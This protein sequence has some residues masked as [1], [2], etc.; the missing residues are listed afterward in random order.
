MFESLPVAGSVDDAIGLATE[1]TGPDSPLQTAALFVAIARSDLTSPWNYLALSV[2]AFEQLQETMYHDPNG[3]PVGTWRGRSISGD[4]ASALRYAQRLVESYELTTL[5]PT[6]LALSLVS[7]PSSG[8][9]ATLLRGSDL[10]HQ[11][12][13]R[14]INDEIASPSLADGAVFPPWNEATSTA[15][16]PP[17]QGSPPAAPGAP[18]PPV[19]SPPSAG[20]QHGSS[21][22]TFADSPPPPAPTQA[23]LPPPVG[24]PPPPPGTSSPVLPLP[25]ARPAPPVGGPRVPRKYLAL[26]VPLVLAAGYTTVRAVSLLDDRSP[27]GQ[28]P[29]LDDSELITAD[30]L[31]R[32]VIDDIR[33]QPVTF[34]DWDLPA[35]SAIRQFYSEGI[36]DERGLDA[37]APDGRRALTIQVALTSTTELAD[38][39]VN[40]SFENVDDLPFP[41]WADGGIE[42]ER[43]GWRFTTMQALN[44]PVFISVAVGGE[45]D[46]LADLRA[47]AERV[48]VLQ[49]A[50]ITGREISER[51][52]TFGNELRARSLEARLRLLVGITVLSLALTALRNSAAWQRRFRSSTPIGQLSSSVRLIDLSVEADQLRRSYRPASMAVAVAILAVIVISQTVGLP[53]TLAAWAAALVLLGVVEVV[54]LLILRRSGGHAPNAHETVPL[55][56]LLFALPISAGLVFLSLYLLDIAA[57]LPLFGTPGNDTS[58]TARFSQSVVVFALLAALAAPLPVRLIKSLTRRPSDGG[59][60][61]ILLLR[62]FADDRLRLYTGRR[63]SDSVLRRLSRGQWN[64]FEE[65]LVEYIAAHGRVKTVGVPGQTL[66]RLGATR[67][68]LG[69][70]WLFGVVEEARKSRNVVIIAGRSQHVMEEVEHLRQAGLLERTVFIFPPVR[71]REASKR[72]ETITKVLTG[73][74]MPPPIPRS[75]SIVSARFDRNGRPFELTVS[76]ARDWTSYQAAVQRQLSASAAKWEAPAYNPNSQL[77]DSIRQ[78]VKMSAPESVTRQRHRAPWFLQSAVAIL[79]F[80]F[81]ITGCAEVLR[82]LWEVKI[83]D[84][85]LFRYR[86][87]PGPIEPQPDG[88]ILVAAPDAIWRLRFAGDGNLVSESIEFPEIARIGADGDALFVADRDGEVTSLDKVFG[89]TADERWSTPTSSW[90][91][92]IVVADGMVYLSH[93]TDG[94]IDVLDADSGRLLQTID[95]RG[96]PWDLATTDADLLVS[97]A[98]TD[99]VAKID[100]TTGRI[101]DRF[102]VPAGPRQIVGAGE[103]LH[104]T[105]V[106]DDK[107]S[108]IDL[109]TGTTLSWDIDVVTHEPIAVANEWLLVGRGGYGGNVSMVDRSGVDVA[110]L[111]VGSGNIAAMAPL[112]DGLAVKLEDQTLHVV[113]AEQLATALAAAHSAGG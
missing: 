14:L 63:F 94:T 101:T 16:P 78:H 49:H 13:I 62:S 42:V 80:N 59:G 23:P 54:R 109:T 41:A 74:A 111:I 103:R 64:R 72:Y 53:S 30:E 58:T 88:S 98:N 69:D 56:A 38:A 95:L 24:E 29:T 20:P 32:Y 37:I 102:A 39:L 73:Q 47:E 4:L 26:L 92:S 65:H 1:R 21:H 76:R 81:L 68:M 71:D 108:T 40:E 99:E 61:Q 106:L 33:T 91:E 104:V 66:K 70:D 57:I 77:V 60:P 6:L 107:L 9:A 7:D 112:G 19:A 3:S 86:L 97:L 15:L 27:A 100:R 75:R 36:A 35:E 110:E 28:S 18:P 93:P 90:V 34:S 45:D 2:G 46:D 83:V 89:E 52:L 48:L 105:S 43:S 87:N 67:L 79:M 55:P 113:T 84:S 51:P 22:T 5:T 8:A 44:G 85:Q 96:A 25:P 17:P 11:Q 82:P 31:G 50:R 10:T 12:L